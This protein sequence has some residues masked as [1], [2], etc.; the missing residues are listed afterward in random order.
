MLFSGFR[1]RKQ[2]KRRFD[3]FARNY[4]APTLRTEAG[5]ILA[6]VASLPL[7][8]PRFPHLSGDNVLVRDELYNPRNIPP[9]AIVGGHEYIRDFFDQWSKH[10]EHTK[11]AI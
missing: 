7:P 3:T 5:G 9:A 8:D 1:L 11:R 10:N 6:I 4:G 2:L